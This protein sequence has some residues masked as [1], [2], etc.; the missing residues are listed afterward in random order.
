MPNPPPIFGGH[1]ILRV[2]SDC[3]RNHTCQI[4]SE[5]V[6]G[7]WSPRWPKMTISHWLGTSH[8]NSVRTN[9]LHCDVVFGFVISAT[10]VTTLWRYRN[11]VIVIAVIIVWFNIDLWVRQIGLYG[12]IM[13]IPV[14]SHN[15]RLASLCSFL[16]VK[17][18]IFLAKRYTKQCGRGNENDTIN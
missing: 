1:H 4:S 3:G 9:V 2:L 8:Y 13:V 6:Q 12:F 17:F 15:I 10:V 5:S 7:F 16:W 14:T 11:S 18:G